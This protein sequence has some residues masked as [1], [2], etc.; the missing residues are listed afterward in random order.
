MKNIMIVLSLVLPCLIMFSCAGDSGADGIDG[1][2]VMVFQNG[3]APYASYNGEEDNTIVEYTPD[4]NYGTC[5]TISF[6]FYNVPIDFLYR[7][8]IRFDVTPIIPADATVVKAYITIN[9][10]TINGEGNTLMAYTAEKDWAEGVGTCSSGTLTGSTWNN[11]T[12][13]TAWSQAG[14]DYDTAVAGESEKISGNGSV[15]FEINPAVVQGWLSNPSQN[16]GLLLKGKN[17]TTLGLVSLN[18]GNSATLENRPKLTVYYRL[19]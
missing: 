11:Y 16:T 8:L 13:A 5:S 1:A 9:V 17:E 10:F 4:D 7:S 14:G 15:T 6:G 18:S 3:V 12:T 19:P 2:A